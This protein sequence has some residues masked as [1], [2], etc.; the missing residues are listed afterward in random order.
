MPP[1]GPDDAALHPGQVGRASPH[2]FAGLI[3][4]AAMF[5]PGNAPLDRALDEHLGH[6]RGWY[7]ELVGPLLVPAA[8]LADLA[9]AVAAEGLSEPLAV[10][11]VAPGGVPEA[12]AAVETASAARSVELVAVELPLG[13]SRDVGADWAALGS[14]R[15]AVWW[16]VDRERDLTAQ[17]D[18]LA[19][20][21]RADRPGRREA[22]DRWRDARGAHRTTGRWRAFLRRAIDVDLT[23]KLT[24]GLHHAVRTT[25]PRHGRRAARRAQ[26]PVR[27]QGGA[28]RRRGGRAGKLFWRNVIRPSWSSGR[29]G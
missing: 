11:V 18:R 6:R 3:D 12:A 29:T 25:D 1:I 17:L 9:E 24:A 21:S 26:H 20:A 15:R 14:G 13:S 10:A 2:L 7:A 22:A 23:F 27:D 8:R 5:P 28:E 16:E 4:D 19:A